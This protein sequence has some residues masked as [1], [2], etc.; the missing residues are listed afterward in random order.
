M[1]G[2]AMNSSHTQEIN[3]PAHRV[4]NRIG[5]LTGKRHF[6]GPDIMEQLLTSEGITVENDR[7]VD[8]D[9]HFWNPMIELR[10]TILE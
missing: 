7:I 4:V 3:V 8:F 6:G 9:K 1:V 5:L 10:S 2:W